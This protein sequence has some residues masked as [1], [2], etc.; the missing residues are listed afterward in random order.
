MQLR[1]TAP[2]LFYKALKRPICANAGGVEYGFMSATL[3]RTIAVKYSKGNAENPSL[4]L[5]M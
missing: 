1:C 2:L 3:D 4:I 5:E